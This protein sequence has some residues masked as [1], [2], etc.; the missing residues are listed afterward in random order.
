LKTEI[1]N[2]G[3]WQGLG[4]IRNNMVCKQLKKDIMILTD[5]LICGSLLEHSLL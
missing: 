4:G 5:K 3:L 1:E 2:L